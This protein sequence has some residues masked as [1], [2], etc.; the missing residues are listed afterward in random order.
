[1]IMRHSLLFGLLAV[2]LS[3]SACR[4]YDDWLRQYD[5][6]SGGTEPLTAIRLGRF[7][8]EEQEAIVS[9]LDR[10]KTVKYEDYTLMP[11][12]SREDYENMRHNEGDI[13][14]TDDQMTSVNTVEYD[15]GT[16]LVRLEYEP[17]LAKV[18]KVTV[19]SSN[20]DVV[21]FED[22]DHVLNKWMKLNSVGECDVTVR[23]EGVNV[24]ERHIH[25]KVIGKIRM[26]LYTDAF[27]LNDVSCRLK[28]KT[29]DLPKGIGSLYMNVQDSATVI[30]LSRGIDQR[31]GDRTFVSYTDTTSY[32]LWQH[33]DKFRKRKR[34]ILR[35]V[36]DAVRKYN[37]TLERKCW[38]KVTEA[39]AES[40][41]KYAPEYSVR[42]V[43]DGYELTMLGQT[44]PIDKYQLHWINRTAFIYGRWPAGRG[45]EKVDGEW[46]MTFVEPFVAKRIVLSMEVIGNN[47]YLYFEI[48]MKRSQTPSQTDE[49]EDDPDEDFRDGSGEVVDSLGT[50]LKDY[51][52][53]DFVDHL[54][55]RSRDSLSRVLD[56]LIR[57]YPDSTKWK[58][59]LR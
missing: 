27:W 43:G 30:G 5:D 58:I 40:L 36:S 21:S 38:I 52:V 25:L 33:T 18:T 54:P 59:N 17:F 46:Y 47:P 3:V 35:N 1:M 29:K 51:F 7:G 32:P 45:L 39:Q 11:Y 53:Y 9:L 15:R 12:V 56:G 28:Y 44:F 2:V 20:P 6:P 4:E 8:E 22:T 19:T 16:H 41:R 55:L 13:N 37:R 48:S 57:D 42:R 23:A 26:Q 34:V 14:M 31:K 50:Q 49:D 10:K 24:M